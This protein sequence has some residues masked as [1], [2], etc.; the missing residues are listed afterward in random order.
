MNWKPAP[1]LPA[2]LLSPDVQLSPQS[3]ER[4]TAAF[5]L[6]PF[7]DCSFPSSSSKTQALRLPNGPPF[8]PG[9]SFSPSEV[10]LFPS[11]CAAPPFTP[12][13]LYLR[14]LILCQ[15]H[16]T[17]PPHPLPQHSLNPA[18]RNPALFGLKL[19]AFSPRR[20][21][22][23]PG[24]RTALL[25]KFDHFKAGDPSWFHPGPYTLVGFAFL[26]GLPF[27]FPKRRPIP[28]PTQK[29]GQTTA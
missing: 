2:S 17:P 28:W 1:L 25:Q 16:G 24:H 4:P 14:V 6:Y 7:P 29:S 9:T 11:P 15:S 13:S 3:W 12:E 5:P 21:A 19:L 26:C 23:F 10:C 8:L 18:L 27:S 22:R 20:F